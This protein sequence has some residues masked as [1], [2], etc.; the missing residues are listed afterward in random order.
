LVDL[1]SPDFPKQNSAID[2]KARLKAY[3]CTRRAGKSIAIAIDFAETCASEEGMNCLYMALT[4]GSAREILWDAVKEYALKADPYSKSHESRLEVRFSNGS[5]IKFS[6]ADCSEKQMRKVLGQKYK[7]VAI[8]EAGSFTIDMHRLVYQMIRPATADYLG[9]IILLGTCENIRQTFF[10]KITSGEE[11]GWSVHKWTAYDN[12][13][14]KDNWII[15]VNEL[16][17]RNPNVINASWFKTHYLNQWCADD[18]LLILHQ[19]EESLTD[20]IPIRKSEYTFILGVD[21]GFNDS[22]AF[23][24]ICYYDYDKICYVVESFKEPELILSKVASRIVFLNTKYPFSKMIIDGANKQGV[25]EMRQRFSLPLESAQKTEKSIF[26]KLL[27]DDFVVGN[28]KILKGSNNQLVTEALQL[29]WEDTRKEKED[30]RCENHVIDA[31]L[32]SWRSCYHFLAV[33]EPQ[34]KNINSDDYMNQLEEDE[35]DGIKEKKEWY[36]RG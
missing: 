31:L 21:L 10:E 29:Q 32:Y 19:V 11:P 28:V 36:R 12:P 16:I 2:D 33:R 20:S 34:V 17:E 5:K 22:S 6:G 35:A 26:L 25:E 30:P 1:R 7:K 9:Q 3:N 24:V 13:H 14:M 15:E 18:E 4:I 8:D 23:V 27:N